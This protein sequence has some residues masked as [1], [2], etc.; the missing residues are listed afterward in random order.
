MPAASLLPT[1]MGNSEGRNDA[2]LAKGPA[3]SASVPITTGNVAP[4]SS[5]G[6][7]QQWVALIS[8]ANS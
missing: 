3:S 1:A 4:Y 6:S 5:S 8:S 2:G 7:L